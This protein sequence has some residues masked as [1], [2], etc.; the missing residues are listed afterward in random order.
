MK[1]P[2]EKNYLLID[3][4]ASSGVLIAKV[5][6]DVGIETALLLL[7]DL[8]TIEYEYPQ[9][10]RRFTDLG[11]IQSLTLSTEEIRVVTEKRREEYQGP[12]VRSSIYARDPVAYG[13]MRMYAS[14][15]DP[16]PIEVGVFY[17]M[18]ESAKWIGATLKE[19]EI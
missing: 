10:F 11:A 17:T 12:A 14:M 9:G 8:H 4:V 2:A 16:S 1:N 18:E 15:I 6:G 13:M 3:Q 5:W 19:L 7:G